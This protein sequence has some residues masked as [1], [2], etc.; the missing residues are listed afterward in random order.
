VPTGQLTSAV[1]RF[2][3]EGWHR[4]PDAPPHRAYLAETHRHLFHVEVRLEVFHDDREVEYHD[5]L[6]FCREA[7]PGG[8]MGTSSCEMMAH[9][10]LQK[11]E[12]N[13]PGR[14]ITV[15]VFEDGE[16][17]AIISGEETL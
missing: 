1:I 16:V 4:W 5:L 14:T 13:Y 17:G 7:F 12:E 10:L 2:A 8:D 11:V 15:S 9:A 6:D 3:V